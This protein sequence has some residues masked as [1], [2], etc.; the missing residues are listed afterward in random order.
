MLYLSIT[1]NQG[2]EN[3]GRY[4]VGQIVHRFGLPWIVETIYID[5]DPYLQYGRVILRN[6]ITDQKENM[7]DDTILNPFCDIKG[8]LNGTIKSLY[9]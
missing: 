6:I 4:K 1:I 5:I 2:A 8:V 7:A 9:A 3:M